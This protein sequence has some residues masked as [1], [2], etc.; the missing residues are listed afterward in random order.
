MA[1]DK[2][3]V[4]K[5][6]ELIR[7]PKPRPVP[8]ARFLE[9]I[10]GA[11][12]KITLRPGQ[13]LEWNWYS[14]HEEGWSSGG[15]LWRHDGDR[16]TN[17]SFSDGTDCDGRMSSSI[18]NEAL[19]TELAIELKRSDWVSGPD[20]GLIE[21]PYTIIRPNWTE[22]SHRQRDYAAEAAGY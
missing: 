14:R 3:Q 8:N 17:E 21:K 6:I 13:K 15:Q 20:G 7:N 18:E 9:W 16:V 19:L 4:G 11:E 10:N 2:T 1:Y 5:V 22:V 12:V